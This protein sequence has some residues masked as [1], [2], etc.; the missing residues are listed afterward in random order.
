MVSASPSP[1]ILVIE[2]VALLAG[3]YQGGWG[4][5]FAAGVLALWV[6]FIP[7]FL[8]IF[9]AGP[10]LDQIAARP[11]LG[12]ALNAIT[13]A[14]VG[15]ILNLAVWFGYKVILPETGIDGFALVA[16]IVSLVLLQKFHF[17]IQYMVPIGAAAGVVWKIVV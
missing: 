6:T 5:A 10:L 8:W 4:M 11:R 7:C 15:V 17:P 13:A 16:A 12:A 3:F 1:L 9:L 2:F 14:V